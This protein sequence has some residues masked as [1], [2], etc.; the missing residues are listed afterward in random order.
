MAR[1]EAENSLSRLLEIHNKLRAASSELERLFVQSSELVDKV[2][3][4]EG[5]RA[6][7]LQVTKNMQE[8]QMS[9]NLQYL[10]FNIRWSRRT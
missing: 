8:T 9:F 2:L 1:A 3:K 10:R 7:L 6:A 5:S 4:A